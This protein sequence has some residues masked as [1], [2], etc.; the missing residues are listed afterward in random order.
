MKRN[1]C[2]C[3]N[4]ARSDWIHGRERCHLNNWPPPKKISQP[5]RVVLG[6]GYI[7]FDEN[8][9]DLLGL[10]NRERTKGINLCEGIHAIPWKGDPKVK[11]VLE[12]VL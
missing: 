4:S 6:T 5:R 9:P 8:D 1:L 10:V 7:W 12:R 2:V 3:R 11:L